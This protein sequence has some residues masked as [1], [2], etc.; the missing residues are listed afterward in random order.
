M[1]YV[2]FP[3]L[4]VTLGIVGKLIKELEVKCFSSPEDGTAFMNTWMTSV[5]VSRT[6]Y[7]GGSSFVGDMAKRLLN[8]LDNLGVFAEN[9]LNAETHAKVIPFIV[10]LQTFNEVRKSCF[11]QAVSENYKKRYH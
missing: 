2:H 1:S 11:G 8:N 10:A 5:N 7:H 4:H 9:S 3:E 6:I